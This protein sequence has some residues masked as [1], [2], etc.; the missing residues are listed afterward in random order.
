[1]PVPNQRIAGFIRLEAKVRA[2]RAVDRVEFYF[3]PDETNMARIPGS[4]IPSP[5]S[6]YSLDWNILRVEPGVYLLKAV[7]VDAGGFKDET[8]ISVEI[9]SP[10]VITTPRNGDL[11]GPRVQRSIVATT[12][13][14]IGTLPPGVDVTQVVVYIN[15]QEAGTATKQTATDGSQ[16]YVYVWDTLRAAPWHDPTKS[17]DRVITA[18]VYYTGG[19]TFAGGIL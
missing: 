7:A 6:V 4:P 18:R 9:S 12:V 17:G 1:N 16:V 15:G 2:V 10:F 14:V 13:G 5:E 19:D 11:V 8:T 3:G